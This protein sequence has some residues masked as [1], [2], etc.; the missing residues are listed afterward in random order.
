MAAAKIVIDDEPAWLD[1]ML[2]AAVF[3]LGILASRLMLDARIYKAERRVK[4]LSGQVDDLMHKAWQGQ[5]VVANTA[6]G[7]LAVETDGTISLCNPALERMFGR[8]AASII[9]RK[10]EDVDLHPE[11]AR[12]A[13]ESIESK[14]VMYSEIKLPGWPVKVLSVRATP[15]G[16]INKGCDNAMLVVQD[17][18]DIRRR[19]MHEREFV[20]NVS[21]ELRTPIT[22]VLTTAETLLAGA[23]NDPEVVDRFLATI[24]QESHRLSTLTDDLLEVTKRDYGIVRQEIKKVIVQE[25]LD[26]AASVVRPQ[27][28]AKSIH[29][30]ITAPDGLFVDGDEN[31][32]IQM[33]RN[34]IDNAVK[35][36]LEGGSVCVEG[37]GEQSELVIVVRDT[38]IGIPHGEVDRIF[39][40]FY[41][42]DK[43]KSRLKGGTGLGLAIVKDIVDFCGGSISVDTQL[44]EGSTFT[45]RLP[46]HSKNN[47]AEKSGTEDCIME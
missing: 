3:A 6:N 21:H 46:I 41:R 31:Q 42:V 23:K 36:T 24:I 32:M 5:A 33:V 19:Q 39:D 30:K 40:R 43:I 22:A 9:G 27:A 25:L 37:W 8:D 45:V 4:Y 29:L 17:I 15:L 44:G 35:Y 2:V 28:L 12:L 47:P 14:A 18:S 13:Y 11:L 26:R 34:L 16:G 10:I 20:G 1:W 38:G 7:V